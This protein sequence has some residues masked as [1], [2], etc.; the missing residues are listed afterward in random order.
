MIVA[1]V[2]SRVARSEASDA[3]ASSASCVFVWD[4]RS[5]LYCESAESACE[6][7]QFLMAEEPVMSEDAASVEDTAN[8]CDVDGSDDADSAIIDGRTEQI[9]LMA[10]P[11]WQQLVVPEEE[12]GVE[13]T[14]ACK[15]RESLQ[16]C[17]VSIGS[18]S[19][20]AVN[21]R[22]TFRLIAMK[23]ARRGFVPTS[24]LRFVRQVRLALAWCVCSK[25][26]ELESFIAK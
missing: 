20:S 6:M 5:S 26:V 24:H 22:G 1:A 10:R 8:P 3:R 4:M 18:W 17:C 21:I 15:K 2:S 11:T 16:L 12:A 14:G 25:E 9:R 19:F 23:R 13:R 7:L